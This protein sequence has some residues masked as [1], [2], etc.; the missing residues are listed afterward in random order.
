[1][2]VNKIHPRILQVEAPFEGGGL[3]NCYLIDAPRR[4]I[5]DTGTASV[6]RA[7]LLPALEEIGWQP[8]DLRVIIN[9]HV[10]TDHAGG[11]AEMVEASGAGVHIHRADADLTDR[12]EYLEMFC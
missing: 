1:M 11:N 5:I 4:A 10:H 12:E 6:P 3:V 8:S 9:T 7:A 2:P